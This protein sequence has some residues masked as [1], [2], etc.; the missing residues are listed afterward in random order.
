MLD[1]R[2]EEVLLQKA[3]TISI[4]FATEG[5]T[6]STLVYGTLAVKE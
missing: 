4:I 5:N 1:E 6:V 3:G 2:I